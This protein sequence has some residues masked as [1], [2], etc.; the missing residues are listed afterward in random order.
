MSEAYLTF[1]FKTHIS[2]QASLP[3][4]YPC[5]ITEVGG[6]RPTLVQ[7]RLITF[8]KCVYNDSS[9]TVIASD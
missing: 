4:K 9:Y 8:G 2:I 7:L 6:G 1:Q 5:H 3:N